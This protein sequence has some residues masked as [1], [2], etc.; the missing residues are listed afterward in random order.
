MVYGIVRCLDDGTEIQKITFAEG[1]QIRAIIIAVHRRLSGGDIQ[2][3]EHKICTAPQ[4]VI[5]RLTQWLARQFSQ[6]QTEDSALH[7]DPLVVHRM[8][9]VTPVLVYLTSNLAFQ[10]AAT[11]KFP[12]RC[13]AK[14]GK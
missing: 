11:A 7:H 6:T 4:T 3:L 5:R 9:Y 12:Q 10:H 1:Q 8:L 14:L 2:H 13:F